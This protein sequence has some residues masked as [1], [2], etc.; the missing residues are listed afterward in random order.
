MI[1]LYEI[2][3]SS[4]L[5]FQTCDHGHDDDCWSI[6]HGLSRGRVCNFYRQ[7]PESEWRSCLLVD[8]DR[9]TRQ[10]STAPLPTTGWNKRRAASEL[11]VIS[12]VPE[13]RQLWSLCVLND[14]DPL[15]F[16]P[17]HIQK[18]EAAQR[19]PSN[20]VTQHTQDRQVVQHS[21][22]FPL[23][24]FV[25]FKM[26]CFFFL[27]AVTLSYCVYIWVKKKEVPLRLFSSL[28]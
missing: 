25:S 5:A 19:H 28:W 15:R 27:I 14:A 13:R 3:G 10:W 26:S 2:L 17:F 24:L 18:G 20:D 11:F 22:Y 7:Q 21:S 1:E 23:R 9:S 4:L 16:N 12:Q 6:L 8:D